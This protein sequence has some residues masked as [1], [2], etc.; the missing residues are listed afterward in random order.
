MQSKFEFLIHPPSCRPHT[1]P[2]HM[3]V[4]FTAEKVIF[5]TPCATSLSPNKARNLPFQ[6]LNGPNHNL[7]P[8]TQNVHPHLPHHLRLP[9]SPNA[10]HCAFTGGEFSNT[11]RLEADFR[12]IPPGGGPGAGSEDGRLTGCE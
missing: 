7:P 9:D 5:E 6:G 11:G 4:P 10:R 2:L 8:Y 12:V 1:Q 3:D